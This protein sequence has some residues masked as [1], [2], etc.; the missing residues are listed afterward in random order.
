MLNEKLKITSN[1]YES[2]DML[3]KRTALIIKYRQKNKVNL[4]DLKIE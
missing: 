1:K 3:N 2:N 4:V